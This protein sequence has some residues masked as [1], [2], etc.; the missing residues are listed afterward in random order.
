MSLIVARITDPADFTDF[1]RIEHAAFRTPFSLKIFPTSNHTPEKDRESVEKHV[2]TLREDPDVTY[3]KVVDLDTNKII[4]CCK[5]RFNLTEKTEEE[6]ARMMPPLDTN[7]E[8]NPALADFFQHLYEGRKNLAGGRKMA[9]LHILITDP[10]HE[11]RG[12]G[13]MLI[14][15]GLEEADRYHL[16]AYLEAS[17]SGRPLYERHGFKARK[18]TWFNLADYG[19]EGKERNTHMV[20]DPVA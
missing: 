17:D 10:A 1:V 14:R 11:R 7:R 15:W 20:R 13:G 8:E 5:W 9:I 4:A 12:A 18:E 19:G 3:L 2:K 16:P 6:Q